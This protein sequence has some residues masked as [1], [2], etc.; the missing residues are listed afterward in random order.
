MEN[1]AEIS[2]WNSEVSL[3]CAPEVKAQ[4][5]M[6]SIMEKEGVR[7]TLPFP[8]LTCFFAVCLSADRKREISRGNSSAEA[9]G[10]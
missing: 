9:A 2:S 1:K 6:T 3:K 10:N 7:S 5:V 4:N 8:N